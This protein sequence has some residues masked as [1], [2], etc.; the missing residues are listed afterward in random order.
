MC[1]FQIALKCDRF[2]NI[3]MLIWKHRFI[4]LV[5][6]SIPK[7]QG[8]TILYYYYR[9]NTTTNNN[10]NRKKKWRRRKRRSS[11]SS[12]N[13]HCEGYEESRNHSWYEHKMHTHGREEFDSF[14]KNI[15]TKLSYNIQFYFW[16]NWK[17]VFKGKFPDYC[18][19]QQYL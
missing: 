7:P 4:K 10:N 11:S 13:W 5:P 19:Y 15:S 16:K 17:S 9:Y 1:F 3:N 12:S 2:K 14:S 8:D 6:Q 18:S